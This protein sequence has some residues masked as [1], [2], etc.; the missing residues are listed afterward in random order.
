MI[1]RDA[2]AAQAIGRSGRASAPAAPAF[3]AEARR[4]RAHAEW[5]GLE[6]A[7]GTR[8]LVPDA[9]P[10]MRAAPADADLEPEGP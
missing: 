9:K 2:V 1:G 5:R 10:R 4:S 8:R 7:D 3:V 6:A